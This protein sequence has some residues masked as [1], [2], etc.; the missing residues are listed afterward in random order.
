MQ[1]ARTR[2]EPLP[3]SV[4]R[5][6]RALR[7]FHPFPSALNAV[8]AAVFALIATAGE[9]SIVD[10]VLL[11]LAMLLA[12]AA[13]GAS[14]D[15]CDRDLDALTKPYKPIA[16][17]LVRPQTALA[18]AGLFA[19]AAGAICATFGLASVAAGA[20]GLAAGIGYNVR[21]KRTLF[22]PLPFMI[23][24]PALPFW[25]WLSLGEFDP[26]LWWL[27]IFAPMAAL[28]VHLSNTL[29]DL[30]SDRAAGVRGLAHA[31]GV[32][33]SLL[34]AWGS[35]GLALIAAPLV[36]LTLDCNRIFLGAAEAAAAA[37][38]CAAIVLYRFLPAGVA[39]QAGFGLISCATLILA[40]G[41]LAALD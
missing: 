39:L 5:G 16:Q 38:L 35:F 7:L 2:H 31:L 23:A 29:P 37:L 30:E 33:R 13:I 21:L 25:V 9:V 41:W 40:A 19:L 15:H 11:T 8:A 22:S 26:R 34:V 28:A 12:Q 20:V 17:G 4:G 6:L 3:A 18:L 36:A 24:L 14:N 10:L 32:E 1:T 27:V